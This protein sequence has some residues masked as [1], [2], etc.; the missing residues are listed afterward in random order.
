MRNLREYNVKVN[1]EILLIWDISN[2]FI[3]LLLYVYFNI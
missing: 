2:I 3:I 1:S